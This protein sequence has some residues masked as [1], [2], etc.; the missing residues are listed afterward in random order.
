[1]IKFIVVTQMKLFENIWFDRPCEWMVY[2]KANHFL[3]EIHKHLKENFILFKRQLRYFL[4][5]KPWTKALLLDPTLEVFV[6]LADLDS[7]RNLAKFLVVWTDQRLFFF[8][9]HTNVHPIQGPLKVEGLLCGLVF[10]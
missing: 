6:I 5:W 10:V 2:Y 7:G 1:M 4:C 9:L 8:L 3:N